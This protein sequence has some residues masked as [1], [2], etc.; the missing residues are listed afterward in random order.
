ML[1]S[2]WSMGVFQLARAESGDTTSVE[3]LSYAQ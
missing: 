3:E 1:L 2:A